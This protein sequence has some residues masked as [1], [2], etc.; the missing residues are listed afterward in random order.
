MRAEHVPSVP[1]HSMGSGID[2]S[3]SPPVA[4]LTITIAGATG[5]SKSAAAR[6][7]PP[8]SMAPRI[9]NPVKCICGCGKRTRRRN[10]AGKPDHRA[11]RLPSGNSWKPN[12][13]VTSRGRQA[14]PRTPRAPTARASGAPTARAS[15]ADGMGGTDPA[16]L[17]AT[18]APAP[19]GERCQITNA[20]A[21]PPAAPAAA[22]E[23]APG[24]RGRRR[25]V[26]PKSAPTVASVKHWLAQEVW[27]RM[28]DCMGGRAW[29]DAWLAYAGEV[30]RKQRFAQAC[31][32]YACAGQVAQ[33][34]FF[35]AVVQ[36]AAGLMGGEHGAELNTWRDFL[37]WAPPRTPPALWE[38]AF[39]RAQW[40]LALVI[41]DLPLP[42]DA[43]WTPLRRGGE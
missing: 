5:L 6:P 9:P 26:C 22:R 4:S 3:S 21:A 37:G 8:L 33:H 24:A 27:P 30:T 43:L 28:V 35:A 31:A 42:Q 1:L 10:E 29:A 7:P 25:A 39:L 15:G 2:P 20:V 17:P 11:K 12:H 18:A 14:A 32:L 23:P 38:A 40:L 41:I 19:A 36:H 16:V 34:A 13:A